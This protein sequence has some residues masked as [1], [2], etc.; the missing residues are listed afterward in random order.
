[1]HL[2][3]LHSV[4]VA[5]TTLALLSLSSSPTLAQLASVKSVGSSDC[6]RTTYLS[7]RQAWVASGGWSGKTLLLLDNRSKQVL[8]V[9]RRGQ[10]STPIVLGNGVP[11]GIRPS[12][13]GFLLHTPAN[14]VV[15][16][17]RALKAVGQ[18]NL[19][20]KSLQQGRRISTLWQWDAAGTDLIALSDLQSEGSS[21]YTTAF[22][23]IPMDNPAQFRI[24]TPLPPDPDVNAFRLGHPLV[25][26]LDSTAYVLIPEGRIGIYKNLPG[27]ND[28]QALTSFPEGF[29]VAPLL[30]KYSVPPELPGVMQVVERAKMPTGL[31]AW[32]QALFVLTRQP[33]GDGHTIWELTKIDPANDGVVGTISLPVNANHLTVIPGPD[34][35]AFVEKGPVRALLNQEILGLFFIPSSKFQGVPQNDICR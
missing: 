13:R 28:L 17:D 32:Q 1:M 16:M 20:T 34:Y 6:F 12:A 8:R 15:E 11:L 2:R 3:I 9:D 4:Q 19:Q 27:S 14:D 22:L 10:E 21:A 5:G 7:P 23:R 31:Y 25:A 30:P 26:A 29:D 35:W 24:L 33:G 18:R